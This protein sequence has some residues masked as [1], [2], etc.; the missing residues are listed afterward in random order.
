MDQSPWNIYNVF[1]AIASYW[2]SYPTNPIRLCAWKSIRIATVCLCS[3][4]EA[5]LQLCT[6]YVINHYY[7]IEFHSTCMQL[8]RYAYIYI[9][10]DELKAEVQSE[11]KTVHDGTIFNSHKTNLSNTT[12]LYYTYVFVLFWNQNN[13]KSLNAELSSSISIFFKCCVWLWIKCCPTDQKPE[14]TQV[15][16]VRKATA[17]YSGCRCL[18]ARWQRRQCDLSCV[19]LCMAP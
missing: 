2:L 8:W 14:S 17:S 1:R 12:L 10:A 9:F 16:T 3:T 7:C 11:Q 5:T 18:L 6:S 19:V 4:R 15:Q 13:D